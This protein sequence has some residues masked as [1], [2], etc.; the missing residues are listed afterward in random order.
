MGKHTKCVQ[1]VDKYLLLTLNQQESGW[2]ESECSERLISFLE[3]VFNF[4]KQKKNK[5]SEILTLGEHLW[6]RGM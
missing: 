6:T 1:E 2:L 4:E 5:G 3:S